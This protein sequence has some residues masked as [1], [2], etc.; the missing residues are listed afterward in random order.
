MKGE[1]HRSSSLM[2]LE[3]WRKPRAFDTGP[4][5]LLASCTSQV[6]AKVGPKASSSSSGVKANEGDIKR[7]LLAVTIWHRRP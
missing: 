5:S 6:L 2:A 7:R 1:R 3:K 4:R